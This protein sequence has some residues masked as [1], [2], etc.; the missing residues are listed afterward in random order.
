MTLVSCALAERTLL[1]SAEEYTDITEK[2]YYFFLSPKAFE[3]IERHG[4]RVRA[5]G[6]MIDF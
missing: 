6:A 4:L 2:R 5:I 1:N 3:A